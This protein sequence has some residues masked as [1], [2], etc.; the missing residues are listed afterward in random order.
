MGRTAGNAWL[1]HDIPAGPE[2]LSPNEGATVPV[3]GWSPLVARL[4]DD[5]GQT[6]QDHR[7]PAD[8]REGREPDRHMIGVLGVSMYLPPSVTSI[9][10]PD[11]FLEPSTAYK[12]E[13]LAIERRGNQT[14][15]S[16]SFRTRLSSGS[17][18]C[19]QG[20]PAA[21]G[22]LPRR[23]PRRLPAP[24]PTGRQGTCL[25]HVLLQMNAR[26]RRVGEHRHPGPGGVHRLHDHLAAEL[27]RLGRV[28]VG[29]VGREGDAPVRRRVWLIV[30]QRE[31][32]G[33]D[34]LEALRSAG[35]LDLLP[36]LRVDGAR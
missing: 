34:V 2:L 4:Q 20:A 28:A 16:G 3:R 23:G 33:D 22:R 5:H 31:H 35:L 26:A 7:L 29:V 32:A 17:A 18:S 11:G 13:V 15:S 14:L 30:A 19:P 1:T 10:V 36:E 27:L 21:A 6:G 8:H 12:W 25:R 9:A 24:R